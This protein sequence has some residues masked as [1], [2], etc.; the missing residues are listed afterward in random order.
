MPLSAG[1]GAKGPRLYDWGRIQIKYHAPEG[2]SRWLLARR[3][4]RDQDTI[5][6]YFAMHTQA[7]HWRNGPPPLDCGGRLKIASCAPKAISASIIAK[8]A[9]GTIGIAISALSWL[10]RLSSQALAPISAVQ[11]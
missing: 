10:P 8:R 3:S 5:A 9:L 2:I 11:V 7:P 6:Y 1:E 4:L